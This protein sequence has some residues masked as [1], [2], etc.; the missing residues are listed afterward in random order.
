MPEPR[1][2][3]VDDER[4][5]RELLAITLGQAGYAVTVA[6]GG[7]AAIERLHRESF[8][9][10]VTDLRMQDSDGMDVLRAVRAHAPETIVVVVTAYASTDTAVEA[11]KLGAYDYVTKPF[12]LD[13]IRVTLANALERKHLK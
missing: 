3:V 8:D 7:P 5:M 12:K 4:S 10:V 9:L 2:L 13:E 6:E 11:M 1:V